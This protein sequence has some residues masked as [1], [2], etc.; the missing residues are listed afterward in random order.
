MSTS[1]KQTNS[2]GRRAVA[3]Y[4][5]RMQIEEV[6]RDMKSA[7]FELGY[8]ASKS[9]KVKCLAA[10]LFLNLIASLVLILLGMAW[11]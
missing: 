5:T 4:R 2:L 7:I 6:F 1:L 10:L 3:I 8:N 9:Y 11:Q